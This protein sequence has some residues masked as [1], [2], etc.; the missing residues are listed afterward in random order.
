[1]FDIAV[2]VGEYGVLYAC[3]V[4]NMAAFYH[5]FDVAYVGGVGGLAVYGLQASKALVVDT[6]HKMYVVAAI[7]G[8]GMSFVVA[9][10]LKVSYSIP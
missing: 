4:L 7:F 5:F 8:D 9:G 10:V 3:T 6:V 2:T 1:M